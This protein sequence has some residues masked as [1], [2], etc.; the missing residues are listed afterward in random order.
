MWYNRYLL[1]VSLV[2]S[3]FFLL[4]QEITGR[5]MSLDGAGKMEDLIGASIYYAPNK[6]GVLTKSGGLFAM[7]VSQ[8]PGWL[9]IRY[10]GLESDSVFVEKPSFQYIHL[11]VKENELNEVRVV[12]NPGQQDNMS[13]RQTEILTMKTLAKAAC[14][15][16]SESF[17]TNASVSVNYTDGVTGVKQIQLLGLSGN[18]V[19]TNVEGIPSIR[20]LKSTYGLNYLPGSWIQSIDLSKGT[21]SVANGYESMSGAINVELAKPDTSEKYFLNTYVN[22]QGRYEINQQGA[23]RLNRNLSTGVFTHISQQLARTDGNQDGFMDQPL[24]DLVN[25]LNRW[26]YS[27][28]KWMFQ[29]G[30][31]YLRENR[32]GGQTNFDE[33]KSNRYL[34][35]G[36]GSLT[37]RWELFGKM[38]RLFPTSP[39]KGLGLILQTTQHQNDSYFAFKNYKG[40]EQS[41]YGNLIYQSIIGNTNHTWKA[42][43]SFLYDS[44]QESFTDSTFART[45]IVPGVFGEYAWTVPNVLNLVLGQRLDWHNQLGLQWIPRMNL[46]WDISTDWIFRLSAGKGWRRVNPLAENMGLLANGRR[47][48]L[49]GPLNPMEKSWNYGFSLTKNLFIGDRKANVVLDVY[50][51][52]FEHQWMVDMENAGSI[53][54]YSNPGASFANS[55]QIEF[56]YSPIKRFE[57]K[58]AYRWQDVQADYYTSTGSLSRLLKPFFNKERVLVNISYATPLDR[59]KYDLTW[60]WNGDRRVPNNTPG[61]LHGESAVL[62]TAPAF[63]TVYAQVTRQFKKWE[64]YVGGEN[65]FNFTQSNPIMSAS[66]PFSRYFDATMVW[67]PIVGRMIYTGMRYKIQ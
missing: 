46:K 52:D 55:A 62:L 42:G 59:W 16:L 32:V 54:M 60:Q 27:A 47:L 65:L 63:S 3:T 33:V 58:A 8:F 34:V 4:G 43:T 56:N 26:K 15:N 39:W 9:Y 66:D 41:V 29:W 10:Q 64:W 17:E 61:H 22:S 25:V 31:S 1:L 30:G 6:I 50:R 20:G 40:R 19:Q 45:E 28:E 51:T 35:Y 14:C 36:F 44:Y 37:S 7:K 38:A 49:I 11:M 18:Y 24:F 12:A 23:Y 5:V 13:L 2:F 57:I 53:R 48:Q 21:S 67:G